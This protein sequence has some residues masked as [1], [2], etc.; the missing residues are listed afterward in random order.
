MILATDISTSKIGLVILSYN[1]D[2]VYTDSIVFDKD[3][4]L[5]ER[6]TIFYNKLQYINNNYTIDKI[7]IEEPFKAMFGG[8]SS[9]DTIGLLNCFNGMCRYCIYIV[10]NKIPI[11]VNVRKA[12]KNLGIKEKK[13]IKSKDKKKIIIDFIVEY[14][15]NS[16]T[17]YEYELT[18]QG[19]PK[20]GTDDICDAIVCALY[21][22]EIK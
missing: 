15:K 12:R 8:G 20:I 18:K 5:E 10:F 13:G 19:N 11:L 16:N 21:G 9:A 4:S 1:K 22:I 2:I 7:V 6:A 17:P 14:Y 3:I